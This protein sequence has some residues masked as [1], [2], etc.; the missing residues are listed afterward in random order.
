MNTD[1]GPRPGHPLI[2]ALS[3]RQFVLIVALFW[4]YVALS[5]VLY[6]H[7][8]SITL[9]DT[10]AD[11]LFAPWPPRVLQHLI[12]LVPLLLCFRLSLR[13]GWQP[14]LTRLPAQAALAVGFA[15]LPHWVLGASLWITK[16]IT[17]HVAEPKPRLPTSPLPEFAIWTASGTNFLL[18]YGFGLALVTGF[19]LYRRYRDTELQIAALEKQTNAARLSALRMQL[20]P[21]TLFNLLNTIRGQIGFDPAAAQQ[22]VV[23]LSD[24]LRKLLNAGEREF[25]TLRDELK[26]V[27]LYLS[28]QRSRF[29]DRLQIELPR[30]EQLPDVWVPSLILQPLV[31]NAVVH[32]LA[33]HER[34]VCVRVA[35][36]ADDEK[37]ILEVTNDFRGD[38]PPKDP[39]I[40]LRNVTER[41]Q[42]HFGERA[43]FKAGP[44]DGLRWR[45]ELEMPAVRNR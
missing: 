8:F 26:F 18:Q 22:L 24:L 45:A 14:L 13:I 38:A 10:D 19:A 12:L 9:A 11:N 3:R 25:S 29:A 1:H 43:S 30:P 7:S 5:N 28:L 4:S 33:G 41:L 15:A 44:V 20:S 2:D 27:E 42:A 37:L 40:G 16:A 39:G 23:Q 31:E 36:K 35:L 34:P 32:G 6:A 21:H 17:G